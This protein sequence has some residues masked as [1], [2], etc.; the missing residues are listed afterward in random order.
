[1]RKS[2]TDP[3]KSY[4]R[5]SDRI[6]RVDDTWLVETREG[7]LGPFESRDDA[8]RALRQHIGEQESLDSARKEVEKLREN[9]QVVDTSIWDQQITND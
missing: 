7:E 5:S 1:M 4:F 6:F 2:D 3:N 9:K 8:T